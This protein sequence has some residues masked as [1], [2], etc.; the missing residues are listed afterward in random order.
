MGNISLSLSV[1]LDM[2]LSQ[3]AR[4]RFG[5]R[6]LGIPV[7]PV[8]Q[9]RLCVAVHLPLWYGVHMLER[10]I[11]TVVR[12]AKANV[13]LLPAL[14]NVLRFHREPYHTLHAPLLNKLV[15]ATSNA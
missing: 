4:T 11:T 13:L 15:L 2:F 7:A 6:P 8:D 9:S 3:W 1:R 10:P 12:P 14:K 5:K